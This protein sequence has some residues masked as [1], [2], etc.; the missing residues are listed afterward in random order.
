M[1]DFFPEDDP[2]AT[3]VPDDSVALPPPDEQLRAATDV[4]SYPDEVDLVVAV[5][6]VPIGRGYAFSPELKSFLLGPNGTGVLTTVGIDTLRNWVV[7]VLNTQ[8][9]AHPI[10]SDDFGMEDPFALIGEPI[11]EAA[12]GEYEQ[13]ISDAVTYHPRITGIDNY[14]ANLTATGDGVEVSFDVIMDDDNIVPIEN[15]VLGG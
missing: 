4:L 7:K 3:I 11:M 8:K 14:V 2:T 10:Y 1:S 12:I 13:I 9:G 5:E 6:P 15:V